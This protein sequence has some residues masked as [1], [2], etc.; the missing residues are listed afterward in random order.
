MNQL[1]KWKT[2]SPYYIEMLVCRSSLPLRLLLLLLFIF[3]PKEQA[4]NVT[5]FQLCATHLMFLVPVVCFWSSLGSVMCNLVGWKYE[6]MLSL[7]PTD[8]SNRILRGFSCCERNLFCVHFKFCPKSRTR[9]T[10]TLLLLQNCL[11]M[12][13]RDGLRNSPAC[14]GTLRHLQSYMRCEPETCFNCVS[15]Q[16]QQNPF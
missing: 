4:N 6:W 9:A 8:C 7:S 2:F 5:M 1:I 12:I 13:Y 16:Q 3:G 10:I 15:F 11:Y 14:N